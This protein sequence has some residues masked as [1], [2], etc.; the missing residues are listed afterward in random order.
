M[1]YLDNAATT[2]I[3][4]EVLE[5]MRPYFDD[6][7]GN[8]ES[9]HP[10]GM[11]AKAAVEQARTEVASLFGC[12]SSQILFTSG[13]SEGNSLVFK[14]L[15]ESL[16]A[17]G[18]KHIIVSEIEHDSVLRAAEDCAKQGFDVQLV[19]PSPAGFVPPERIEAAI[20]EDT[21]LVSVM[22]VNNETGVQNDVPKIGAICHDRG[23]IFHSDCVQAAETHPLNAD[24]LHCDLMTISAHKIHGPKGV[25]AV[26]VRKKGLLSPLISGGSGQEFG[27]R[28]GTPNVPGV[29]GFGTAC[30]LLADGDS[31]L[32]HYTY[33]RNTFLRTLC[34]QG[35]SGFCT[36]GSDGKILSLQ[37]DGID[38]Q[39]LV[40]A[41]GAGDVCISSGSACRAH[42]DAPSRTLLA[43]GL[44]PAKARSSVRVSFS[45]YTTK[46][47]AIRAAEIMAECVRVLRGVES[48]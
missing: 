27:L 26:Y 16:L 9:L 36:N 5:S 3:A 13:G 11:R 19:P 20:R 43:M 6:E 23:I 32:R 24:A 28:G 44:S 45:M 30:T 41:M 48:T 47:E 21:G 37:I 42:E 12:S 35:M 10:L 17:Q 39:S 40:I 15:R 7:Y 14:G 34:E 46:G 25:G 8:P 1:I 33:L 4:Y 2:R 29:V 18:R 38:S 31:A 22:Y